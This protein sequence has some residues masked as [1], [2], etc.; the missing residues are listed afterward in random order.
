MCAAPSETEAPPTAFE[1]RTRTLL[2]PMLVRTIIR[3]VWLSIPARVGGI[4]K[5]RPGFPGAGAGGCGVG[6]TPTAGRPDAPR[7]PAR[8]VT[9]LCCAVPHVATQCF[10]GAA[11]ATPQ[12][13]S[14]R[15]MI[16]GDMIL[17]SGALFVWQRLEQREDGAL[18]VRQHRH[19][20][21]VFHRHRPRIDLCAE[22]LR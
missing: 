7:A 17:L 11:A 8:P 9:A 12:A 20:A 3:T 5:R 4:G 10:A 13:K 1:S 19:A 22:L 15:A 6:M 2:P 16:L 21:D 14:A 18:R